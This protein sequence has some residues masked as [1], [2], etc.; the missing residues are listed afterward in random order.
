VTDLS[1]FD[2]PIEVDWVGLGFMCIK[3]E[4]LEVLAAT[5]DKYCTQDGRTVVAFHQSLF[6]NGLF[7]GEDVYFRRK[8]REA[9]FK[10]MMD[11]SVR[12]GH[13]GQFVYDN[14]PVSNT[15]STLNDDRFDHLPAASWAKES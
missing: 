3:R 12:L 4:V 6:W 1:Q 11:P 7:L 13:L 9:G 10:I 5:S 15:R 8:A 2:G 14:A